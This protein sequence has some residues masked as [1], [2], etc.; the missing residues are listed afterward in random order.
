MQLNAGDQIKASRV[1][2]WVPTMMSH[3]GIYLGDGTV[4]HYADCRGLKSPPGDKHLIVR[5][6]IRAF[7]KNA[8][9]EPVEPSYKYYRQLMENSTWYNTARFRDKVMDYVDAPSASFSEIWERTS[10]ALGIGRGEYHPTGFN[11][12]HLATAIK[13]GIPFSYQAEYPVDRAG[14]YGVI[15]H[16]LLAAL[17]VGLSRILPSPRSSNGDYVSSL[18]NGRGKVYLEDYSYLGQ[19]NMLPPQWHVKP[20]NSDS[21]Q[22]IDQ[23][24]LPKPSDWKESMICFKD[25]TGN[26][27]WT[28][29]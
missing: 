26:Y 10:R 16:L 29:L 7:A 22:L 20:D 3:H 23:R 11:C 28:S 4:V 5:T 6:N 17:E 21:W 18:Y 24:D 12:E 1:H 15:G 8:E 14:D 27:Q 2:T 9:V 25:R 13:K 19:P